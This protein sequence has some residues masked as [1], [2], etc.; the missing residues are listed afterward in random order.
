MY[1]CFVTI[2]FTFEGIYLPL[3]TKRTVLK[4]LHLRGKATD[5]HRQWQSNLTYNIFLTSAVNRILKCDL[6]LKC[7]LIRYGHPVPGST[8]NFLYH[9]F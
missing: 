1:V 7:M 6:Q 4:V 5:S 8:N 9:S 3:A 2:G